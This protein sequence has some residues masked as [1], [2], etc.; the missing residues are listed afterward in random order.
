MRSMSNDHDNGYLCFVRSKHYP[1][2]NLY[3]YQRQ[4]EAEEWQ[5]KKERLRPRR[6][7]NRDI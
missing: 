6:Q 1:I 4:K 7:S 2:R 3:F 5:R